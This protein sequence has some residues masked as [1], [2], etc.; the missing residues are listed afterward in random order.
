MSDIF[1]RVLHYYGRKSSKLFCINI[2]AMDGV[3]FDEL[4][5]YSKSYGFRGLYVEPIPYLFERL[6]TNLDEGGNLFENAAISTENGTIQMMTIEQSAIDDGLVHPCFY[7]MSAVHPPKNGLGSEGDREIVEKWGRIIDVPCITFETLLSKHNITRVDVVKIDAEGH[8]WE[9]FHQI[10]LAKFRPKLIRLEWISLDDDQKNSII[11]TFQKFNYEYEIANMDIM[12]CPKEVLQEINS[13]HAIVSEPKPNQVSMDANCECDV[14][15]VTGLWNIKR[16]QLSEGW[17]RS[18]EHYLAKFKELLEVENPMIIFGEPALESFVFKHRSHSNTR[19]IRRNQEWFKSNFYEKIQEIRTSEKWISQA[20]WL[21]DSTQ[22]KLEMYN[23]LVM[24]K[25]FLLHDAML[26]DPF[27]SKSMYWIDAGLTNTVHPGYFT[28]DKVLR[29]LSKHV[30]KFT[31]VCFPYQANAEIHG[32][33]FEEINKLSG[34]KVELVARGGFFGGPTQSIPEINCIYYELM[35]ST[36]TQNL[37]GTEESLFSIMLY[38]NNAHIDYFEIESNGLMN[39]FFED[40]KN[41][42]LQL[43]TQRPSLYKNSAAASKTSISNVNKTSLYVIGF[44]SPGQFKVLIQSMMQYDAN[45]IR[46]PKKYLLN[47]STDKSTDAEYRSLCHEWGFEMIGTG[48]NLGI[49]GGRQ[50]IAEHF[51]RTDQDFMLFFEDDMFFYPNEI[52]VCKNGFN[53]KVNDLYW[54]SLEIISNGD[55]DFLKLNF[56]EF[57]GNNSTQWAWY[58]VSQDFRKS[59]WPNN[60]MLPNMGLDPNAPLTEFKNIRSH[61]GL[62]WADGEIYYS[63]WP[64]IVSK[65]GNRKMFMQ[66]K[67][68]HPYEQTWMSHIYQETI[69]G[70]IRPAILLLTPTEHNRFDEYAKEL[71][72]EN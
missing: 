25:M 3:M 45:Y 39:K 20:S 57:F 11:Q 4:V 48:T 37:M 60:P 10:D 27:K 30:N 67:W 15:L 38:R 7:G 29:K 28:H 58:N 5:G 40:L 13:S 54:K 55:Y 19:F 22:A 14:T 41:N 65:E 68:A 49:C 56:T 50:Y 70:F 46:Q 63:N 33:D 51:D 1:D 32:F 18:F 69:K 62:A 12:A 6:K 59:R 72:K 17:T 34:K 71:R 36:L 42:A 2:G 31:F 16:D 35:Q 66:T 8:D 52:E 24:S 61:K 26:M 21:R 44:N 64:Q 9:I 43:K 47:N 53:R 23:P